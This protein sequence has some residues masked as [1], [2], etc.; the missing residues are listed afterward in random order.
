MR[1]ALA[2]LARYGWNRRVLT[3][4]DFVRICRRERV[5]VL[6]APLHR[7]GLYLFLDGRPY[8]VL[9]VNLRG[10]QRLHVAFHELAHHLLHAPCPLGFYGALPLHKCEREAEALALC[11]LIPEP[12][13][14]RMLI[15]DIIEEYGYTREMLWRRLKVLDEFGV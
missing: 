1:Y 12:L 6:E 8:I 14:R 13:L 5:E 4:R 2:Q 15:D 10:I 9:N 11:A 7:S 3:E